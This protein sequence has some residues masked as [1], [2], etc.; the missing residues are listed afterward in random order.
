MKLHLCLSSEGLVI[1]KSW[2]ISESIIPVHAL[3]EEIHLSRW[4]GE[5]MIR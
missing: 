1:I 2:I 3:K 5:S 4:R